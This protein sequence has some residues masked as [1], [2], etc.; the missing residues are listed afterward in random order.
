MA[1]AAAFLCPTQYIEPLGNVALEA[2][3]S[4]TPVICTDWGGFSESVQHGY[5]GFRCRTM[6]Q[7]VWAA[8]HIHEINPAA[9]RQWS[10]SNYSMD[11][12]GLMFQE[13]FQ[14]LLDLDGGGWYEQRPD[15][16]ELDWLRKSYSFCAGTK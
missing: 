11:R 14:S 8:N 16:H 7:F 2:Q 4:G 1:E 10:L 15:R 5:T 3:T 9:C 6:D 13:Y 12:V